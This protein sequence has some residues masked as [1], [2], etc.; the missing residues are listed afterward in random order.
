MPGY[1]V[2]ACGF[3]LASC[4]CRAI[5]DSTGQRK[6]AGA[7]ACFL[8][9]IIL[10]RSPTARVDDVE[11]SY[12]NIPVFCP[13]NQTRLVHFGHYAEAQPFSSGSMLARQR[14]ATCPRSP[15]VAMSMSQKR[16]GGCSGRSPV[17]DSWPTRGRSG[18]VCG[19]GWP[20][21]RHPTR[22]QQEGDRGARRWVAGWVACTTLMACCM[23]G[24]G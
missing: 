21:A 22:A 1:R 9:A 14:L 15:M 5:M 17:V 7:L 23:T 13:R 2:L 6:A 8:Q 20:V 11:G 16:A 3:L 12:A 24:S 19:T 10:P 18:A 4:W